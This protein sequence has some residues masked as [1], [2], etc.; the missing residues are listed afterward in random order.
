MAASR[1]P[2]TDS[3]DSTSPASGYAAITPSDG[4]ELTYVTRAIYV[5]GAGNIVAVDEAG[6]AVT[7]TGATAGSIIPIRCKRVNSTNTTATGLV[8]LW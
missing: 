5:G 2:V 7:F 6:N 1:K 8:A 4:T 3:F